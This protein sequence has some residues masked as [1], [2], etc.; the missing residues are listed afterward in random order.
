MCLTTTRPKLT[1]YWRSRH[2][3]IPRDIPDACTCPRLREEGHETTSDFGF[4]RRK[5]FTP[6]ENATDWDGTRTRY[7]MFSEPETVW[8]C[9]IRLP[10]ASPL[11]LNSLK[12]GEEERLERVGRT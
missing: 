9:T 1:A 11:L 2:T 4:F 10:H 3:A 6:H 12:F 8:V 5:I 7:V